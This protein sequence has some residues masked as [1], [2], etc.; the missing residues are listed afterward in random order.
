MSKLV[1]RALVVV[2][3]GMVA[4]GGVSFASSSIAYADTPEHRKCAA[5]HAKGGPKVCNPKPIGPRERE[6]YREGAIGAIPGVVTG[7]GPAAGLGAIA[8][9]IAGATSPGLDD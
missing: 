3:A 9:C 7:N 2:A 5:A 8:G 6:C 1:R 4:F